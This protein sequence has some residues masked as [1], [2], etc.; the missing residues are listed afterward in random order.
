LSSAG[1]LSGVRIAEKYDLVRLMDVGGMGAIYEAR[2]VS[3]LKRCVVKMMLKSELAG[4]GELVKRFFRE[5]RASG[6]IESEHVV[7]AFDS[8]TD[9]CGRVYYVMEYL[10]G[11][12]LRNS[13]LRVGALS[14][15]VSSKIALQAA[16]GLASA[17]AH[18]IVHRDVKP[19]NL[20]LSE[21]VNQEVKVKIL[22]FGVAKVTLEVFHES[23]HS[24][25]TTGSLLGTPLYMSPEQLKR[26]SGI[27]ESADVW[28]LGVVLFECLT[29]R[30]PWGELQSMS[31]V[32][33]AILTMPVPPVQDLA[34]WVRPELAQLVHRALARDLTQRFRNAGELCNA[35]RPL[36][37]DQ[38]LVLQ[39]IQPIAPAERDALAPRL[40]FADTVMGGAGAGS[41]AP[42]VISNVPR[43]LRS[44]GS[45]A[46]LVLGA[47]A[48][49]AGGAWFVAR[50]QSGIAA[51]AKL[52][53][54]APMSI[55]GSS[56]A[57]SALPVPTRDRWGLE[58]KP[59]GALVR[60]NGSPVA[61]RD[62]RAIIEGP[63]GSEP[64]VTL[65]HAGRSVRRKLKITDSGLLPPIVEMPAMAP[66][67]KQSLAPKPN[68]P[69]EPP[70]AAAS[71]D[72]QDAATGLTTIFE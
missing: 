47:A 62:G 37:P 63:V 6:V 59:Q 43:R 65:T 44:H 3:T 58:V 27:D 55:V 36:V 20:F 17:H 70:P 5:A 26:A 69:V 8:G 28:S 38:R 11:Q 30:V 12:D 1:D 14:P 23:S 56:A 13:L 33:A 31:E 71:S 19:G 48:V 25:T 32:I 60:V 50:Q 24:L 67:K 18:G 34:P 2:Q 46:A 54:V 64:E 49:A 72:S 15:V 61:V 40:S 42:V 45:Q 9:A 52:A 7:A 39:D 68:P 51:A 16:Y 57:P 4:D 10:Q 22:D 53:P 29:G 21:G 41:G 66:P 35:L